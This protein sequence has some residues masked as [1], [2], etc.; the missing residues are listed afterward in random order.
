MKKNCVILNEVKKTK[1]SL[2]VF[3]IFS[4]TNGLKSIPLIGVA[5]VIR[6]SMYRGISL[7]FLVPFKFQ[8]LN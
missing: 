6:L 7:D 3:H 4:S 8:E 5:F 1:P 2:S